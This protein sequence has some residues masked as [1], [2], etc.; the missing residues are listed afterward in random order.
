M[1]VVQSL[2]ALCSAA[3]VFAAPVTTLET[4]QTSFNG[5]NLKVLPLGDSITVSIPIEPKEIVQNQHH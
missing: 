3:S 1:R 4:R 5:K 2:L